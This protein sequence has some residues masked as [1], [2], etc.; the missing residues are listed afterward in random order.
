[1]GGVLVVGG[2]ERVFMQ[3]SFGVL[4]RRARVNSTASNAG[5]MLMVMPTLMHAVVP[6]RMLLLSPACP[7]AVGGNAHVPWS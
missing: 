3:P 2:A 1:M 5:V 7:V 4:G 6:K